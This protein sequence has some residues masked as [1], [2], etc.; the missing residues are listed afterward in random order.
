MSLFFEGSAQ[1]SSR[2]GLGWELNVGLPTFCLPFDGT[3][4]LC[5]IPDSFGKSML[6][7]R[8]KEETR[9][10][11]LGQKPNKTIQRGLCDLTDL[12]V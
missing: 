3:A 8:F 6:R 4:V 1:L 2:G 7:T 11:A 5:A 10:P 9:R 12:Y